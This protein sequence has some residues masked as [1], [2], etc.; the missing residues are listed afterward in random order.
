MDLRLQIIIII[1]SLLALIYIINMVRK[2]ELE[3]KYSLS[4]IFADVAILICSSF[5]KTIDWI[6][7]L[8]GVVESI[9]V[10]F[11]LGIAFICIIV[12]SLTIAQSRNSKKLKD[13][14]QK[15]A[16][17]EKESKKR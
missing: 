12:L 10:I 17:L 6:A 13:L 15:V 2:E 11:F 3:L 16:L 9:N 14:V 8:L 7:R 1:G 5:P 4:W